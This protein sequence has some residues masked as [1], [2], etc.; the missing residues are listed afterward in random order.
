MNAFDSAL[1]YIFVVLAVI[2][3]LGLCVFVW[4]KYLGNE[5]EKDQ[6]IGL[7]DR[8]NGYG[9]SSDPGGEYLKRNWPGVNE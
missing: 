4:V 5:H 6:F 1:P 9:D 2:A 3:W 7:G 8:D